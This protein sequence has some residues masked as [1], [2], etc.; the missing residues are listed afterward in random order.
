MSKTG[1]ARARDGKH[2]SP[3]AH[4]A[5]ARPEQ[6]DAHLEGEEG[7]EANS[8]VLRMSDVRQVFRKG[9]G[10]RAELTATSAG[11]SSAMA[12]APNV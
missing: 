1:W 3:A 9:D 12:A 11:T 6:A 8:V 7:H 4:E 5:H 2:D 10:R